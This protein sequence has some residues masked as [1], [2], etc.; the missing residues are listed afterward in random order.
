MKKT[1]K[2]ISLI[3]SVI[4]IFSAVSVNVFAD[5][6]DFDYYFADDSETTVYIK[7]FSGEVP[8][9]GYIDIPEK[10]DGYT[11]TGI[12]ENAFA[13]ISG[14][15]GIKI[16]ETLVYID[17]NAFSNEIDVQEKKTDDNRFDAEDW[18]DAH[19]Q[20]YVIDGSTL[21]RYEGNDEVITI[22]YNCSVIADGAFKNNDKIRVVYIE[23]E[24]KKIGKSAFEG[25][26]SLES[27]VAGN[28]VKSIEIGKNAFNDTPW[29]ENFPSDFVTIASTLV[30]YKGTDPY[31]IIPNVFTA[32]AQEAFYDS[33]NNGRTASKIKV[34]YT[35]ELFGKDCFYLY[36]SISKVYPELVVFKDS[37]AEKYC[38]K[39]NID[40]TFGALPGDV[41]DDGKTTAS[42]AR[43][44]LR[45][46]AKLERPIID[47]AIKEV[48]DISGDSK[49]AA[50]DA[51][52]VLRIAAKIDKFS[53]QEILSIPRSAYE[54]LFEATNAISLARDYGASYS[55]LE[56]QEITESDV[57][58]HSKLYL[59]IYKDELTPESKANTVT[60]TENT[61][62]AYNNLYPI[63]LIDASKIKEY[64]TVLKDGVY[65]FTL[66]L[67]DEKL[68]GKD[69]DA[70]SF[71]SEMFP[72]EKV[73]HFTNKV[74]TK[75]WYNESLDYNMT[76]N[77]CK[78]ELTVD[79]ETNKIISMAVEMNY[80]FEIT[81]KINGIKVSG[82]NGTATATRTDVI[83][84][85][86]FNYFA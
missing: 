4:I 44:V 60:F 22:P 59:D 69:V 40:Y 29:M 6:S 35:I 67:S 58:S 39:E 27:V 11:V 18:Y 76:Y 5:E 13:N 83:K 1:T 61:E 3:L 47:V 24:L 82:S 48:A 7:S 75:Y 78:L 84:Y 68:S 51:R 10:I 62:E 52:L 50:D 65:K 80:D 66:V 2:I 85:T 12:T 63:S 33:E 30:K 72:V 9:D 77:N 25:C 86:N 56:Y 73:S 38:K 42:D 21:V 81:G 54:I 19:K 45:V 37:A 23:R 70:P 57:N 71:T 20:D 79:A 43:Y 14:I 16:P 34:P 55:M 49:I 15:K 74:K 32:I 41:D 31:V 8:K 53:A 26:S 64:T 36:D 17:E 28:G 46:A